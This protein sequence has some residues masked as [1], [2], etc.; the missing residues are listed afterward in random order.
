MSSFCSTMISDISDGRT[1]DDFFKRTG[2]NSNELLDD[3][4]YIILINFREDFFDDKNNDIILLSESKLIYSGHDTTLTAEEL[5]MIKFF[6]LSIEYRYPTYTSQITFEVTRDENRENLTYSSYRVSF[7][8]NE[9]II[10]EKNFDEFKTV[11]E[12]NVWSEEKVSEFC[13]VQKKVNKDKNKNKLY[14]I[15]G[16]SILVLILGIVI[17]G[18][19]I[20]IKNINKNF[21]EDSDKIN[22]LLNEN[23]N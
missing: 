19:L 10:M 7:Y 21:S 8:F 3:C 6:N 4:K 15:I 16:L 5:F 2:I 12:K 18:L 14:A 1:M 22:G 11:I 17:I 9:D 13:D 23:E 20:K